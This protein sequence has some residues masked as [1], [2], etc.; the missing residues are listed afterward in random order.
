MSSQTFSVSVFFFVVSSLF[1]LLLLVV[2][3]LLHVS[4]GCW[5]ISAAECWA[6]NAKGCKECT[7]LLNVGGMLGRC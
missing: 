5:A 7:W 4:A 1:Y 6:A 3:M 2:L